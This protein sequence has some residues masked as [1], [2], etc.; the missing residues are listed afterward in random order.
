MP[1]MQEEEGAQEMPHKSLTEMQGFRA[2]LDI[3]AMTASNEKLKES[4]RDALMEL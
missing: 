2:K 3:M 1:S 4:F